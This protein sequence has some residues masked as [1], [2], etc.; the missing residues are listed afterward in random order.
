MSCFNTDCCGTKCTLSD[1]QVCNNDA[2]A[3]TDRKKFVDWVNKSWANGK[4]GLADCNDK[5]AGCSQAFSDRLRGLTA[6]CNAKCISCSK[7]F[8]ARLR[9]ISCATW[10]AIC[11]GALALLLSGLVVY[12]IIE[13]G[14]WSPEVDDNRCTNWITSLN[15]TK[16]SS[17]CECNSLIPSVNS[18]QTNLTYTGSPFGYSYR[19]A[20]W[21]KVT[22]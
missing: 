3:S 18:G 20:E 4:R 2:T 14:V 5:C 17:L 22:Y 11:F 19:C 10:L 1:C 7:G 12:L 15:E 16:L 9:A 6:D 21:K 13:P 8:W